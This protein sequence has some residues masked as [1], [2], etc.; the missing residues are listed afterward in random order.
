MFF[1]IG[2][3]SPKV[4]TLDENPRRCPQCGLNQAYPTRID[5]YLNLF[6]I[7]LFPVKRGEPTLLCRNCQTMSGGQP[8]DEATEHPS[9]ALKCSHC[10]GDLKVKYAYCPYCG[11]HV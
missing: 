8:F 9:G 11:K 6:F 10:G 1:I 2:G 5:H 3:I 4:K 7:P